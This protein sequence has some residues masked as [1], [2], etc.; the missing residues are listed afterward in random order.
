MLKK[1]LTGC[2]T[3]AAAAALALPAMAADVTVGGRAHSSLVS[4]SYSPN[5]GDGYSYLDIESEGRIDVKAKATAG[6]FSF[7]GRME[8]RSNYGS[9]HKAITGS[10]YKASPVILQKYFTLEN[11]AFALSMGTKWFGLAYLTPFVGLSDAVDRKCYGCTDLRNDRISLMLKEVGLEVVLGMDSENLDSADGTG[12]AYTGTQVGLQYNGAFGPVKVGLQ[13]LS[14]SYSMIEYKNSTSKTS[15]KQDGKTDTELTIMGQYAISDAMFVELDYDSISNAPKSGDANITTIMGLA[16][17]M[18]LSE[19]QGFTFSYDMVAND[20]GT[21]VSTD[22]TTVN[23]MVLYFT[24]SI[25]GGTLFAGYM[26]DAAATDGE[27]TS[28]TTAIA[29]GGRMDF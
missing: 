19:A 26:S 10:E 29:L 11:D 6:D 14:T 1:L 25:G 27:A 28:T 2:L 9:E 4:T 20:N 13:Y 16:F 12:D 18:A 23:K 8:I 7:S 5:V 24:Q 17:S 22:D 3:I 15:T 21:S